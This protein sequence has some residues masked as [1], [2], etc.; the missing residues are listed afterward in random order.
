MFLLFLSC[1]NSM[2]PNSTLLASKAD[3]FSLRSL[4]TKL[5]DCDICLTCLRKYCACLKVYQRVS[6]ADS[7][8]GGER[9]AV[10][11]AA[12]LTLPLQ[13]QSTPLQLTPRLRRRLRRTAATTP[14]PSLQSCSASLQSCYCGECCPDSRARICASEC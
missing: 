7:N 14:A 1:T 4:I 3:F 8:S 11:A 13:P 5:S 12:Q 10:V 6:E 9:A 2:S